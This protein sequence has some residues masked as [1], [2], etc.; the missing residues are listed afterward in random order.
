METKASRQVVA[1]VQIEGARSCGEGGALGDHPSL[2][3]GVAFLGG[4]F[5][6]LAQVAGEEEQ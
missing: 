1:T 3:E 5:D 2:I 6:P 4:S